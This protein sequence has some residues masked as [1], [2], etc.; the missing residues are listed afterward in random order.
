M[1]GRSKAEYSKDNQSSNGD[2]RTSASSISAR[3]PSLN[4]P[5]PSYLRLVSW[6][7]S[8]GGLLFGYASSCIND[9]LPFMKR[10]L[11]LNAVGVGLVTACFMVGAALGSLIG[12]RMADWIGRKRTL[13]LSDGLFIVATLC[14]SFA[15]IFEANQKKLKKRK[16]N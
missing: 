14:S 7:C 4:G 12:G 8:L 11:H 15:P 2:S 13:V 1:E 6:T 9:S 5:T 3:S 16:L 10:E